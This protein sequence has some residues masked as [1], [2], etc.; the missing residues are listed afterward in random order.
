MVTHGSS[1]NRRFGG[2]YRCKFLRRVSF[3][4]AAWRLIPMESFL[5]CCVC[6]CIPSCDPT[7][8]ETIPSN[9]GIFTQTQ[10]FFDWLRCGYFTSL[11]IVHRTQ[12]YTNKTRMENKLCEVDQRRQCTGSGKE[13]LEFLNAFSQQF[14]RDCQF[15]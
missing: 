7:S 14:L 15:A 5:L 9:F 6:E 3:I 1:E 2:I 8:Y 13:G 11:S 4:R 12:R 10:K